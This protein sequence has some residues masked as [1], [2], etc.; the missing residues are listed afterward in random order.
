MLNVARGVG[1]LFTIDPRMLN[2]EMGINARVLVDIDFNCHT[3]NKILVKRNNPISIAAD[4]F[5]IVVIYEKLP[6]FYGHC[7]VLG[8]PCE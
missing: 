5:F 6:L 2:L 1:I 4:V 3:T 8:Q 7:N